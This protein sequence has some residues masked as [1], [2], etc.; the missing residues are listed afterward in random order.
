ML[1]G[2]KNQYG[3]KI[4][5]LQQRFGHGFQYFL[6]VML[7][8]VFVTNLNDTIVDRHESDFAFCVRVIVDTSPEYFVSIVCVLSMYVIRMDQLT[9]AFATQN[10]PWI[11]VIAGTS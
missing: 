9:V 5:L 7:V 6:G 8:V 3:E 2:Y 1:T 10:K 11:A 4:I